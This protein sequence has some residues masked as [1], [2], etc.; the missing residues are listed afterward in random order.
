M[1]DQELG[2]SETIEDKHWGISARPRLVFGED[3]G[4]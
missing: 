3:G 2:N 1:V 4:E